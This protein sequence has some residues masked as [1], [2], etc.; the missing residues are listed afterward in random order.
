MAM[1][2]PRMSR[3]SRELSFSTSRPSNMID[4]ETIL[5]GGLGIR[6]MIERLATDFPEPDSPTMPSVSP[7]FTSKLIPSTA[8]TVPSSVSKYVRRSLTVKTF[9]LVVR[10]DIGEFMIHPLTRTVLTSSCSYCLLLPHLRIQG[11]AQSIADKIQREKHYGHRRRRKDHLPWIYGQVLRAFGGE[12]APR[13][14][15]RP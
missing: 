11:V 1:R 4:P 15:W 6:R 7:C 9:P 2:F 10:S 13:N 3:T 14:A 5:P 12:T 8:L